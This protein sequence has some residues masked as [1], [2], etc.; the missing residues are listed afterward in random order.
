MGKSGITLDIKRAI[1]DFDK[2]DKKTQRKFQSI[3]A[4]FAAVMSGTQRSYLRTRVKN[5]TGTL[6][7]TI[8]QHKLDANNWEIGPDA[9][10][11]PRVKYAWYIE[12]GDGKFQGYHYVQHSI[13]RHAR[14]FFRAIKRA[15]ERP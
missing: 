11:T 13:N 10:G 12:R 9:A 4:T 5:W 8:S 2:Y 15:I 7:S 14:A 1:G 6:A 3:L